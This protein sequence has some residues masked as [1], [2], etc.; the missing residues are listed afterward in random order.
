MAKDAF[1]RWWEWVEKPADSPLKIPAYL[2]D[3]VMQ[4]APEQRLIPNLSNCDS[5]TI[6][7]SVLL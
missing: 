7:K 6:P 3:A 2:H 5:L 4:L 1:D